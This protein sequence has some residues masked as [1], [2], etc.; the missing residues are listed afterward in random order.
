MAAPGGD[1]SLIVGGVLPPTIAAFNI[2]A[3][4]DDQAE[5]PLV[6]YTTTAA[7]SVDAGLIS[8]FGVIQ[9]RWAPYFY[10]RIRTDPSAITSTRLAVGLVSADVA[11]NAGPATTG[12]YSTAQGAWLRY[13]TGVDGTAFWRTVT[14]SGTTA[15]VTTTTS[16][17]AL[18]SAYELL[19]EV[20]SAVSQ[21]R[22][23]V[24]GVLAATHTTNLPSSSAALGYTAR[25]RTLTTSARALRLGRLTW[26]SL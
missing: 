1:T 11:G 20:N 12:S 23:W 4:S 2:T 16:A 8:P 15:T 26:S 9:P 5:G 25:L 14:S 24:N 19:I 17:I 3:A 22:F 10:A 21:V 7:S 6:R 18:D 13:D